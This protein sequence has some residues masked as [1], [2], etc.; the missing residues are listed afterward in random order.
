MV[1]HELMDP[2]PS[3]T[4]L[5]YPTHWCKMVQ[6]PQAFSTS[7]RL[8]RQPSKEAQPASHARQQARQSSMLLS[9]CTKGLENSGTNSGPRSQWQISWYRQ[10]R[11]VLASTAPSFKGHPLGRTLRTP[12]RT[13]GPRS[14]ADLGGTQSPMGQF[15]ASTARA[16]SSPEVEEEGAPFGLAVAGWMQEGWRL[17]KDMADGPRDYL[18]P[19]PSS[20]G[21]GCRRRELSYDTVSATQN[22]VLRMVRLGG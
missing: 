21:H 17:L 3:S 4:T 12:E 10:R 20:N 1:A 9:S 15:L 8:R 14:F 5:L 13:A 7:L 18:I 16:I 19:F 2:A 6:F 22:R 11:S